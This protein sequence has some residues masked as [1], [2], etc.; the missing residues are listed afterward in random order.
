MIS[1]FNQFKENNINKCTTPLKNCHR[2]YNL[3]VFLL[4]SVI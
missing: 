3:H 1:K 2:V 4:S